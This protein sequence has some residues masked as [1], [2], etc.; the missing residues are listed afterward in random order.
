VDADAAAAA[1]AG[2]EPNRARQGVLSGI[3]ILLAFG[4]FAL[5][6]LTLIA[7]SGGRPMMLLYMVLY[8]IQIIVV[9]SW[10]VGRI[11]S[12]GSLRR[13]DA[14]MTVGWLVIPVVA[15]LAVMGVC[16]G[17]GAAFG[18]VLEC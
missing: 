13:G 14:A 18:C 8:P 1:N 7:A 2:H 3:A 4:A 12:S 6:E 15:L 17:Y 5:G 9:T 10:I 16:Y 11:G